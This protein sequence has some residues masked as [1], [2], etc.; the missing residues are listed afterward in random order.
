MFYKEVIEDAIGNC[1]INKAIGM[2]WFSGKVMK[3]NNDI[4]TKL[5]DVMLHWLNDCCIPD[6]ILLE[7]ADLFS[8]TG[9]EMAG[10]NET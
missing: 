9:K 1:N 3:K 8:I 7:K 10:I 4:K 2:D 5:I 6:Y